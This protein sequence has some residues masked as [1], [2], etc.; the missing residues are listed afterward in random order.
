M[1][2]SPRRI[3][4]IKKPSFER[5]I[6]EVEKIPMDFDPYSNNNVV[7]M[8]RKMSYFLGMSL[9]K[10]VK[11]A[12]VRVPTIPTATPPFELGYKTTDDDLL[13]MEL[14]KMASAK[15]KVKGLPCLPKP[16]KPY[17]RTFNGKFVK[18]GDC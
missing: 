17:N 15:A 16:L 2:S 10:T 5:R 14:R 4:E 11:E 18:V 13:E 1:V 3:F 9:R 6:E 7:A 12:A 8:M